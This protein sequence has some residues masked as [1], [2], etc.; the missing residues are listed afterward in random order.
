MK[1][2]LGLLG[3]GSRGGRGATT[4]TTTAA[5]STQHT[6]TTTTAGGAAPVASDSGKNGMTS[7]ASHFEVK[8]KT[9]DSTTFSYLSKNDAAGAPPIVLVVG[10]TPDSSAGA[11]AGAAGTGTM[12]QHLT[13]SSYVD[14]SSS[15]GHYSRDSIHSASGD[16]EHLFS[17]MG[18]EFLLDNQKNSNGAA[19]ALVVAS[20][21]GPSH[22]AVVSASLLSTSLASEGT[23]SKHHGGIHGK[24]LSSKVCPFS[25]FAS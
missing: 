16:E 11:A 20:S 15:K 4:S 13:G 10:G 25:Y 22:H 2:V 17:T 24:N 21:A 1:N 5:A 9:G 12:Q 3:S 7:S 6:T 19:A 8:A 14:K 18:S 23:D